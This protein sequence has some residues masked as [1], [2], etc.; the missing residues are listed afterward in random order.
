MSEEA[1]RSSSLGPGILVKRMK[2][3][4]AAAIAEI[5]AEGV[6]QAADT[7]PFYFKQQVLQDFK[8]YRDEA[9]TYDGDV[10]P[11]GVNLLEHW[12]EEGRVMFVAFPEDNPGKLIG[13]VGVQLGCDER[14]VDLESTIAS[15][16]KISVEK[17]ERRRGVGKALMEK[18]ESW[19]KEEHN[20][21]SLRLVTANTIAVTFFCETMGF[22]KELVD[23]TPWN[24]IKTGQIIGRSRRPLWY[25]KSLA[26][27]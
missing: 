8:K 10:G 3:E 19:A 14:I 16:W 1:V 12:E 13:C 20:C 27:D 9:L 17:G 25:T 18:A 15:I 5:W 26:A 22:V 4:D 2:S 23:W 7:A 21:A 11:Q 24:D 6:I